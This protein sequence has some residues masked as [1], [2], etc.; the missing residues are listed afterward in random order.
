MAIIIPVNT[1]AILHSSAYNYTHA[2]FMAVVTSVY[3]VLCISHSRC[4]YM[5]HAVNAVLPYYVHDV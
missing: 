5:E 4:A 2:M 3:M 1:H